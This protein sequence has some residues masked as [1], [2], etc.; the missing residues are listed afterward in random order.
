MISMRLIAGILA[1]F[2]IS[3][4][5]EAAEKVLGPT[6]NLRVTVTRGR[7]VTDIKDGSIGEKIAEFV[8]TVTI[9][10]GSFHDFRGNRV[11]LILMGEDTT[12]KDNWKVM[13][14]REF[15][16]NIAPSKTF[17]WV[18]DS[19]QQGFDRTLAKSGFDYEGYIVLIK[20]AEGKI[21][22]TA[23]TKPMW[24]VDLEKSWAL[25]EGKEYAKSYFKK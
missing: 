8:P 17:E 22:L 24:T 20:N 14:R 12:R 3:G 23:Q 2:V 18:G 7:R 9:Q 19:F 13:Y 16:L 10:N 1:S 4:L 11:C 6:D 5:A 25:E 15:D 21:V